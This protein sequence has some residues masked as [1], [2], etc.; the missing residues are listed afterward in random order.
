MRKILMAVSAGA[1]LATAACGGGKSEGGLD[2]SIFVKSVEIGVISAFNKMC[3]AKR[4]SQ[5]E[6]AYIES[7]RKTQPLTP[8]QEAEIQGWM[9][10]G[11]TQVEQRFDEAGRKK[12][13][14]D[15]PANQKVIDDGIAGNF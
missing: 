11:D 12:Q 14:A 15:Y 3:G 5:Y 8:A 13:C 2:R 7:V 10:R 6:Q 9:D 4:T 1:L